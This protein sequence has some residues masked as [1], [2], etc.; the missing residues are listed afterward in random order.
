MGA[1]LEAAVGLGQVQV[2]ELGAAHGQGLSAR[3]SLCS[4][5]LQLTCPHQHKLRKL[6]KYLAK[7]LQSRM[8]LLG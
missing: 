4:L 7:H 8:D 6:G 1:S 5:F 2:V 3:P